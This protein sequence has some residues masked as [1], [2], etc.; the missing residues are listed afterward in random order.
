MQPQ[1]QGLRWPEG[2]LRKP[3]WGRKP[4][5]AS[6]A[7]PGRMTG[8]GWG[9]AEACIRSVAPH[10]FLMAGHLRLAQ[11]STCWAMPV[12]GLTPAPHQEQLYYIPE[13]GRFLDCD[14]EVYEFNKKRRHTCR[15][16]YGSILEYTM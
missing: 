8:A 3:S 1:Q 5:L 14:S 6:E 13:I 12:L 2:Q 11:L 16:F 9:P 4:A 10:C 15:M 7:E